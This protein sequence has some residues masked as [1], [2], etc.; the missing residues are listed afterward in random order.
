[1]GYIID[2]NHKVVEENNTENWLTWKHEK[3]PN[4]KKVEK[5]GDFLIVTRFLGI[6]VGS[7]NSPAFFQTFMHN[8]DGTRLS[9]MDS[10]EKWEEALIGHQ[11][12]VNQIKNR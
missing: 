11:N 1:M 10:Y 5:V 4:Y 12:A 6:N 3:G 8:S 9:T 2:E 7:E